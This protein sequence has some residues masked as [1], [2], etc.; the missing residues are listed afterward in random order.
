LSDQVPTAVAELARPVAEA[1][2]LE[3]VDVEF[4]P[5]GGR[6]VLRLV[7][8]REGGITV[9]H[10]AKVSREVSDLLDAHDTVPVEY[11]L[12]CTSPGV[13]RSLKKPADFNRF[14]GKEVTLR[15]TTAIE[16]AKSFAGLLVS[17][18]EGAIEI[19][20]RSHGRL[21]VPYGLIDDA[22]YEHDF[23]RD[24]RGERD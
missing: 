8:D 7:L 16:G 22:H 23:A 3:L 11:T 2:G 20:D 4:A 24:L 14:C 15:T 10:L 21:S 9:D 1:L 17:A 13:N 19:D 5:G 6:N 18:G 12:E